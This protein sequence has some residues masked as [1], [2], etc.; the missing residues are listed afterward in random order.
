MHK[1]PITT[2]LHTIS[3]YLKKQKKELKGGDQYVHIKEDHQWEEILS[4][5]FVKA[6]GRT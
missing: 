1:V 6:K 2:L 3:I 4:R 5:W